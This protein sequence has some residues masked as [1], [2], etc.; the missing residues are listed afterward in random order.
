MNFLKGQGQ[1][2]HDKELKL[3]AE[4]KAYEERVKRLEE[5][6]SK[7]IIMNKDLVKKVRLMEFAMRQQKK[8]PSFAKGTKHKRGN[9]D[10]IQNLVHKI[11]HHTRVSSG[12]GG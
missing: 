1:K 9:S 10:G 2:S 8:A 11:T 7:Q 6:L 12:S 3:L 4:N 5:E